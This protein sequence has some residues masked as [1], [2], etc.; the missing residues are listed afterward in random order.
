MDESRRLAMRRA[1]AGRKA[2]CTCGKVAHGNGG[3]AAHRKMHERK[4]EWR[5]D[6]T[7]AVVNPDGYFYMTY[8][9]YERRRDAA[10]ASS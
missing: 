9:E 10:A 1:H 6:F 2:Y 3:Q 4:G 5:R 7:G 8:S